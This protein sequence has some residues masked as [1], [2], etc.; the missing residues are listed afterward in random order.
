MPAYLRGYL[1]IDAGAVGKAIHGLL[2]LASGVGDD[3]G[4]GLRQ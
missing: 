3:A 2:R 4:P 1:S